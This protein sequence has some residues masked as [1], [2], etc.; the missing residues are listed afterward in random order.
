MNEKKMTIYHEIH[1]L[2]RLGFNKS[3]IERKV[4]VNRDTVRK[5]LAKDFKEM[6]EWTDTLQNRTKKLDPYEPIIL[7]WL[8]EHSDLS[9]AQ[10]ED[11]LLEE[12]STIQ[13]SSSTVRSYIKQLRDQYAIPK[14]QTIRQYEAVPEVEMGAQIQVD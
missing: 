13:V 1:R 9:A 2:H 7:E 12:Y 6:S 10:I 5:Y 3:Q 14:R 11:W 8:K 4:G